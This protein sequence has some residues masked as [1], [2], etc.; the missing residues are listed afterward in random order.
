MTDTPASS[1]HPTGT[2]QRLREDLL[3]PD[4]L[5]DCLVEVCRLH[6]Q[7]ASR[8]SLSAGLPLDAEN[9]GRLTLELAERAAARAGMAARLQRLPLE[10]I[11]ATALPAILVLRDNH[12]CVL[13]GWEMVDGVPRPRVLLPETGQGSVSMTTADLVERYTG[14]VLFVRPHFRFD[15]RTPEVRRPVARHWFWSAIL[16]QRFVYRDVL[17]AA[18]LINLFALAFPLFSMNVYDRVVPNNAVETLWAL[19]V[20]VALVLGAD[21]FMRLLRSHFVDEASARIDVQISSTLMERVLGMRLE[22]RP[23]S[24]GSFASNLR[25][26]EQVRDFIASST[27]TALIDLPFALLFV[28]VTAWI[29]PWLAVPVV[30]AF[31]IILVVGYVLQHRLHELSETTYKAGALRNATL[32]ESLTAIETI[33]SQ[34]A[35]S[36]VQAKWERANA[37]LAK[38]NVKMRALSSSAMYSTNTLTQAVSVAMILVGVYLIGQKELT[39]GALIASTMLAGRALA[40]A[41]QIVGLLMQYQGARTAL[42]SLNRIMDKPV[43][44]PPGETFIQRPQLRGDIEFRNVRFS[45]PNRQDS[46]LDGLSFKITAGERVALIGRVG[47]GKSTIQRLMMGLYQPTDGAVLLDGIDLRQLD[48]ADVRRNCGHVS[49]DVTLF[50]GTLR[51]NIAFGMPY[52]DDS[53]IV[54]AAEVAGMTEFVNRHPRGFD[55][56]VG[57]RGESLSGGQRQGVGI[58]RAVL[59]NAPILLLDE[60]TSAMDFSTEAQITQRMG[61]FVHNKTVVLVTHRTSMLAMVTRV[62]VIDGGKIVADGPRDRIMEALASGRIARAA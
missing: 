16:T 7:A 21:L 10:R 44:R 5:L 37:F 19:A 62:I 15:A 32:V 56:T 3:H 27:V 40:P 35:E 2:V 26:F 43:E 6:G 12:A 17:W 61:S 57:E 48:P 60:P 4:P 42:D 45:Y 33:K 39:M 51:D 11:D 31:A 55:M 41:G 25:G 46:A 59:H 22:H 52:A 28:V 18:L 49:Q 8:A 20:G 24:V 13:T 47:S 53:A 50:Y 54:A 1:T 58:A 29:S 9:R 23:E 14:V 38:T 30:L 34:G 36:V